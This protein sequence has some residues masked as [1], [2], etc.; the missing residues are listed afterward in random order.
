MALAPADVGTPFDGRTAAAVT[1]GDQLTNGYAITGLDAAA[2]LTLRRQLFH[3][4]AQAS[5]MES[6]AQNVVRFL[7]D[8]FA[9]ES[10]G[11]SL[12]L[13][14]CYVTQQFS[15]LPED[16]RA[17]AANVAGEELRPETKCLTLLGT[18]GEEPAWNDRSQSQGHQAIPLQSHAAVERLPMVSRLITQL[19]V[20]VRDLVASQPT[21]P[22]NAG[23]GPNVFHVEEAAGSPYIPAQDF[24][25]RYGVATV[26]GFGGI[27]TN[28]LFAV[29]MF[30]RERVGVET[31]QIFRSLSLTVELQL[32]K[33]RLRVF[34]I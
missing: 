18:A 24:V 8:S 21:S 28:E 10:G 2:A 22:D 11:R 25:E 19:G 27:L 1:S 12:C 29:I 31:A 15:R 34:E 7:Y 23:N 30:S 16:L 5:S 32:L 3:M 4:E 13:V 17:F 20:S 6:A 14:R 26:L 33:H 9:D